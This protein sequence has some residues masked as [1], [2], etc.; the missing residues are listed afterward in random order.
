MG[1]PS[2]NISNV[3]T[4]L[5]IFSVIPVCMAVGRRRPIKKLT[6]LLSCCIANLLFLTAYLV[7]AKPG[8]G[9]IISA[10]ICC[11]LSTSLCCFIELKILNS[12]GLIKRSEESEAPNSDRPDTLS[13]ENIRRGFVAF[14]KKNGA[15]PQ[16]PV[17]EEPDAQKEL[18]RL[19]EKL[20]NKNDPSAGRL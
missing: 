15:V 1:G 8:T 2:F 6:F 4:Y 5:I 14:M 13:E 9:E 17:P 18:V 3:V 20:D 10:V 7:S 19:Y 16:E 11:V 12:R